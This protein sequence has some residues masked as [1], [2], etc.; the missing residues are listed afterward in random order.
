[1]AVLGLGSIGLAIAASAA[2]LN[3]SEND[4]VA[5]PVTAPGLVALIW[6]ITGVINVAYARRR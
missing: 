6:I 4:P 2:V 1:M 5:Y 3:L